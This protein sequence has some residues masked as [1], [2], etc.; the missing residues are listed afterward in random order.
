MLTAHQCLAFTNGLFLRWKAY[1]P[2]VPTLIRLLA[3]QAIC[4][5]ATHFT[6][7][8]FDHSKRP[9][10]CWTIIGTT[11]CVSR[12]IQIWA[13]SNLVATYA[14]IATPSSIGASSP[15]YSQSVSYSN[16]A[17]ALREERRRR[18]AQEDE[19][20][21]TR[22]WM[23]SVTFGI[24]TTGGIGTPGG[25]PVKKRFW[26]WREIGLKGALPAAVLYF[27]MAWA[28]LLKREWEALTGQWP[29]RPRVGADPAF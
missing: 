13:T 14:A 25:I 29:A 27:V 19:R 8:T 2:L 24:G 18:E 5:P 6:L 7:I 10:I 26:D 23:S 20:G 9:L 12:S 21:R 3:L 4:W 17:A 16:L 1:Y 22:K 15:P 28:L 11:T